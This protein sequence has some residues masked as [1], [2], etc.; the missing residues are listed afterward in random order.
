MIADYALTVTLA[1]LAVWV[2][3]FPVH[4]PGPDHLR[5]HSGPRRAAPGRSSSSPAR[6]ASGRARRLFALA[7]CARRPRPPLPGA[8]DLRRRS[9][10]QPADYPGIQHLH[11]EYGPINIA[12]GPEHHRVERNKLSPSPRL[13]HALQARPRLRRTARCPRVDVIHLHHGVWLS[14]GYPT[15][16]AGEEKTI[17]QLPQGFGYHYK[18]S[19]NW[20]MN[21]MIH[22]LTPTPDE[23]LHHL[24]HRLRAGQRAGRRRITPVT[25]HVDGRRRHQGL[26]GL[27]RHQG[28]GRERQYTFPDQ[29]R[30]AASRRH[31][32]RAPVDR[33]PRR[34]DAGRRPPGTC[35]RAACTTT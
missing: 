21:Y 28:H 14:N 26:P 29:A 10:C 17:F 32:R 12:P 24:R 6:V 33:R 7:V 3:L 5:G 23:G 19:D 25:P 30:G 22:N 20:I 1:A 16:A 31:R 18:P 8:H 2:V 9:R 15:F 4:R 34:H 27:R 35:T 13:H 11:Y